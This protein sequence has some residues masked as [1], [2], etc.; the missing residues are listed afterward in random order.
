MDRIIELIAPKSAPD[1]VG[2]WLLIYVVVNVVNVVVEY[3]VRD[4]ANFHLPQQ[5]LLIGLIGGPFIALALA[6]LGRQAHLQR[7]LAMIAATDLL[8]GLRNRRAFLLDAKAAHAA[9]DGGAVLLLDAD[10]FKAINDTYGHEIGDLC[11]RLIAEHLRGSIRQNDV[12]GRIGGEEF[13]IYLSNATH[14]VARD[15][16]DLLCAGVAV[17]V[18]RD[19]PPLKVTLSAG[20]V[21]AHAEVTIEQ[22]LSLADRALY[23]A[24]NAG[25]ARI[26]FTD[27]AA[28]N[29]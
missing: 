27:P 2:K 5:M 21:L 1:F 23:Q 9:G 4:W 16:G 8:T 10:H 25:R 3:F 14:S 15:I 7:Q 26:M 24:K 20:A 22:A 6:M 12:V 11:L 18:P 28:T 13:A 29:T 17:P 19:A